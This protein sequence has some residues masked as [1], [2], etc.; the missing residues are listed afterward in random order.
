MQLRIQ[1]KAEYCEK[2]KELEQQIDFIRK[3]NKDKEQEFAIVVN[4]LRKY[5]DVR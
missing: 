5:E 3:T 1:E 2:I 4:R